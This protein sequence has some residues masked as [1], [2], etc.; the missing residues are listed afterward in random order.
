MFSQSF[1]TVEYTEMKDYFSLVEVDWTVSKYLKDILT[2]FSL[3][4][5]GL[6]SG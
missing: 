1:S 3:L 2:V 5:K 6:E 4:L